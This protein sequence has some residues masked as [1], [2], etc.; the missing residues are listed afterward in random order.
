MQH[1]ANIHSL[2]CVTGQKKIWPLHKR[3]AVLSR[4]L[5]FHLVKEG[6]ENADKKEFLGAQC[7]CL[8]RNE[9]IRLGSF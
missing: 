1:L 6:G 4:K 9:E 8:G 5:K 7:K 3:A 2:R